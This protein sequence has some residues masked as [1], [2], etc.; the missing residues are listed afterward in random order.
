MKLILLTTVSAAALLSLTSCQP[1]L[2][3]AAASRD[4]PSNR[5]SV[6]QHD[7]RN[8]QR[9]DQINEVQAR[10]AQRH[11]TYEQVNSPLRTASDALGN[12]GAARSNFEWLTR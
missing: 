6:A 1:S 11:D 8:L 5:L 9:Q 7:Q 4:N 3:S 2:G 10:D 12:M